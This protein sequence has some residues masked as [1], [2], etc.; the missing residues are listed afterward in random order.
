[1]P[2]WKSGGRDEEASLF[3]IQI[4]G[5]HHRPIELNHMETPCCQHIRW[6]PEITVSYESLR[7]TDQVPEAPDSEGP[8]S[9]KERDGGGYN[10]HSGMAS[11]RPPDGNSYIIL[12]FI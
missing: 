11:V 7:T 10:S 3:R 12:A 4:P 2:D 1:M 8:W 5:L 6:N 9:R